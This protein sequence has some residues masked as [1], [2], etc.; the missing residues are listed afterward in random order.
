MR[1]P[2]QVGCRNEEMSVTDIELDQ[3][4][5]SLIRAMNPTLLQDVFACTVA[6]LWCGLGCSHKVVFKKAAVLKCLK[7]LNFSFGT[8]EG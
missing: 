8:E 7:R 5:I 6:F 1:A 4:V 2:H 3:P